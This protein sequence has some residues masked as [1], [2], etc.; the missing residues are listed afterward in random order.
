MAVADL[1]ELMAEMGIGEPVEGLVGTV[2]VFRCQDL[3][4]IR[5]HGSRGL[6]GARGRDVHRGARQAVGGQG[7]GQGHAVCQRVR[8][9]QHNDQDERR[10]A[11]YL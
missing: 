7:Q 4:W 5:F 2:E 3:E 9:V 6:S 10:R 11:T 1:V 8:D